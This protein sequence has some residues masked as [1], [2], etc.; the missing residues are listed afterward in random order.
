MSGDAGRLVME[1]SLKLIFILLPYFV[2][3]LTVYIPN[4]VAATI[5]ANVIQ[6]LF[7]F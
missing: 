2:C 7:I 4:A 1:K 6:E 3:C 5:A